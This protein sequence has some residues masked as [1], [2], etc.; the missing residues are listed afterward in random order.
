M[1]VFLDDYILSTLKVPEGKSRITISDKACPGLSLELRKPG[2]RSWRVRYSLHKIQECITLGDAEQLN[3]DEARNLWFTVKKLL[4]SNQDPAQ[5]FKNNRYGVSPT[6]AQFIENNYMPH[7]RSYK[8]C[9]SADQT[10][11]DNHLLPHFGAKRMSQ[12]TRYQVVEF[13]QAKVS[14]GYKPG[15]CNRFL[16]LLGFCFNLAR[17][18]E[19]PGIKQNPVK[20]VS[21]LK[22]PH[23]T[24]RF[25]Q[26]SEMQALLNA[27]EQSINPLLKYFVPLALLTGAR[28]R[29]LLDA[30]WCDMDFVAGVWRIP[31]TKSGKPLS[32]PLTNYARSLLLD[33]Q[34]RLPLLLENPPLAPIEWVFPN[35]KTNKPFV[36]IF[37]SW[38]AARIKAGIPDLRIHDLRHSFASALVNHGVPIYDV[39]KLLGHQSVKTTERYSHL[40][41]ERLRSSASAAAV[42]YQALIPPLKQEVI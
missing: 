37:N 28:K 25:L 38:N 1:Q 33:L 42:F 20:G 5:V 35:P 34:E 41:P 2:G 6:Y 22:D 8:R 17:K 21:L 7:I 30:R 31:M 15:Y 12:I 11:L 10:L 4:S 26:A 36:S 18:W 3:L 39:Q 40:A 27:L 32:I 24:E 13:L 29:E 19:V 16:V 14:A 23:K 9:V